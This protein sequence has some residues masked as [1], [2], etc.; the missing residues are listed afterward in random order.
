MIFLKLQKRA[1]RGKAPSY[2]WE[3]RACGILPRVLGTALLGRLRHAGGDSRT[4][5]KKKNGGVVVCEEA[6]P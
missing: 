3:G 6:A 2:M 4:A 1:A 5:T